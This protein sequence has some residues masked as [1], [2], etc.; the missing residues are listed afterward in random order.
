MTHVNWINNNGVLSN[1]YVSI[2]EFSGDIR[3]LDRTISYDFVFNKDSVISIAGGY[4]CGWST[5]NS[6]T[7]INGSLTIISGEL[8]VDNIIIQ[9]I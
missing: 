1:N 6:Y 2:S 4:Q 9:W 8:T 7:T 3:L 5:K